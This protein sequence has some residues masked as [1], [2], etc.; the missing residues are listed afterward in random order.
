MVIQGSVGCANQ[1]KP[2]GMN[3]PAYI[4]ICE[5][6]FGSASGIIPLSL[7]V[8][9]LLLLDLWGWDLWLINHA[10]K[11]WAD[12]RQNIWPDRRETDFNNG[13]SVIPWICRVRFRGNC[14]GCTLL[15]YSPWTLRK[16]EEVYMNLFFFSSLAQP[17]KSMGVWGSFRFQSLSQIR[18]WPA[19]IFPFIPNLNGIW[20]RNLNGSVLLLETIM[21]RILA[22]RSLKG[23]PASMRTRKLKLTSKHWPCPKETLS[24]TPTKTLIS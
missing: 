24:S 21:T 20:R 8:G 23:L 17:A 13:L 1:I 10:S 3:P 19:C 22:L 14:N 11:T 2:V 6:R 15:G 16:R 7:F 4:L 5:L 18:W 9:L 12:L